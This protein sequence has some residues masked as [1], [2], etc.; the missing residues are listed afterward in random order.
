M[1]YI[2]PYKHYD[3]SDGDIETQLAKFSA[4]N[5]ELTIELSAF[6]V[7]YRIDVQR[8]LEEAY[9]AMQGAQKLWRMRAYAYR[10]KD[11]LKEKFWLRWSY[12]GG[13]VMLVFAYVGAQLSILEFRSVCG[14]FLVALSWII[15]RVSHES[16]GERILSRL[17][18]EESPLLA[19]FLAAGGTNAAWGR[20]ENWRIAR[21]Q[22]LREPFSDEAEFEFEMAQWERVNVLRHVCEIKSHCIFVASLNQVDSAPHHPV[23]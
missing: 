17:E 12:V 18:S 9:A 3:P 2:V 15:F 8:R 13:S 20:H 11:K 7:A 4:L 1:K 23:V 10:E 22:M 6:D 21:E 19:S 5:E 16:F 14:M